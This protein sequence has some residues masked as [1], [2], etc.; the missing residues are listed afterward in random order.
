MDSTRWIACVYGPP[1]NSWKFDGWCWVVRKW[2]SQC[3]HILHFWLLANQLNQKSTNPHIL[4]MESKFIL[5]KFHENYGGLIS[6]Y[7]DEKGCVGPETQVPSSKRR[8]PGKPE[9][10][11]ICITYFLLRHTTFFSFFFTWIFMKLRMWLNSMYLKWEFGVLTV[12][13]LVLDCSCFLFPCL[14]PSHL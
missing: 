2:W 9:P 6:Y 11:R 8:L 12:G 4:F 1:M 14:P 3:I 10:L 13:E 5:K 7:P